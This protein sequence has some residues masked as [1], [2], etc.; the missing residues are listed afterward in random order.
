MIRQILFVLVVLTGISRGE[1]VI[2]YV[3]ENEPLVIRCDNFAWSALERD[4]NT[5]AIIE[6]DFAKEDQ[7]PTAQEKGEYEVYPGEIISYPKFIIDGK[8][9]AWDLVKAKKENKNGKKIK[10]YNDKSGSVIV[11]D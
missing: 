4:T 2:F 10:Y 3:R 8:R 5:F 6:V 1:E 7:I 9:V 11:Y